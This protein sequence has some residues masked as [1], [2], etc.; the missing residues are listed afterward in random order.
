MNR[1]FKRI[2]SHSIA[3]LSLTCN[4][5]VLA[6]TSNMLIA[7]AFLL[8]ATL[9][10]DRI[11]YDTAS[12]SSSKPLSQP[13]TTPS[14]SLIHNSYG[15]DAFHQDIFRGSPSAK[16]LAGRAIV[17]DPKHIASDDRLDQACRERRFLPMSYGMHRQAG[18]KGSARY[19]NAAV[20]SESMAT[21][22]GQ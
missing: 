17:F 18:R 2:R 21:R 5:K 1:E 4:V 22:S 3:R 16:A 15:F 14:L 7:V 6:S 13:R 11:F 9:V 8:V 10:V 19:S 12:V 20:S